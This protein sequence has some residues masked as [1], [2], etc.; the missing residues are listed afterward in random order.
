VKEGRKVSEERAVY[1]VEGRAEVRREAR[2]PFVSARYGA[3][4]KDEFRTVTQT[5]GLTGAMVGKL[6]G[7]TSRTVR[8]WI[9]GESEIPYSAWRLL[10]IHAG[11]ALE[12]PNESELEEIRGGARE[13]LVADQDR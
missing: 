10:L 6:L 2:L 12:D 7:V 9:G 8:K 3:P 4:T 11:L 5:L 1:K 13:D